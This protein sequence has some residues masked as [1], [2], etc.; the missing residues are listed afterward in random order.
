[1]NFNRNAGVLCCCEY[2]DI[3]QERNHI[4][5]CCCNCKHLDESFDN[6]IMGKR[7]PQN[8]S[9]DFLLTLQDRL[10]IPWF[11]GARQI[12]PDISV[13]LI[14]IPA[15]LFLS[16]TNMW[17]TIILFMLSFVLLTYFYFVES[18]RRSNFF[19]VWTITTAVIL[20]SV[21]EFVV[22]PFLEILIHEN[23][24]FV[25]LF[26]ISVTGTFIVKRRTTHLRHLQ[27]EIGEH[28]KTLNH[29]SFCQVWITEKDYHCVWVN[30]CI[31]RYNKCI[32]ITTDILAIIFL[33][34]NTNLTLTA[35]CHPFRIYKTILLPDD[36][37]EVYEQYEYALAFV[38]AVYSLSAAILMTVFLMYQSLLPLL[39][40]IWSERLNI[41]FCAVPIWCRH[42]LNI[43]YHRKYR[44]TI[45]QY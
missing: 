30:S 25:L 38:C 14:L 16:A 32:W 40:V 43:F 34:Y 37:S 26:A 23:V 12:A 17:W 45:E 31:G 19:F 18:V 1:M 15:I 11:G 27:N 4:L 24:V 44:K 3:D 6:F 33:L 5:A 29:C 42:R 41:K 2:L 39:G 10:R 36:C 9:R 13:P 21:F 35:V 28:G 7:I 8:L 20:V 22:V